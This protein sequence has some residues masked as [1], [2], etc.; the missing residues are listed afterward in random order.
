MKNGF[1]QSMAWLHTWTGL[2]VGWLLLLIFMAGTASYYREEI[3]RW[4]RPELPR[5]TV[6][7]DVAA[8]RA[9]GFLQHKAPQAESW[10]VSLPDPRTPAMRMFWR[11][12][13]S[14]V[15]PPAEGERRRRG[16][17]RFG[18]ATVDPGT[19]QEVAARET[20]GGDFFY[21]LHFDLHY[22]PVLWAR[23]LVGFCAMFMLVAI[24]TGVITHKKIF[25][26]FFTFRR[27]KGLRSW[28]DFHN[29]SA[30]MA[31]PYHAMIT[32]TGIVT[33][34]FMYL[35]WGVGVAY[36]KDEE[37]FFSEAFARLAEIQT[38]AEGHA[39]A[40]PIQQLLDGARRHWKGA[41][42]AGFTLYHPG[43]ANAVID[44]QQRDGKRLSV[45]TPSLRYNA[46]TGALIQ[47]S[48]ASGG[49]TQTRGVMYGLHLARFADWGLRA[50]FFLSG[51]VGCLMVAS[52]VVLWAVKE[53]PKHAKS[54]RIGFG[55]RLVDALNI[56][57]VAG[58]P[59]AF[60]AY[61][62][63]NRLL[64][65][66]L[67]ERADAEINVFF[68]AWGAA[69]LAAFVWPK[70]LM[71]AWQ[72][73]LGAALFALIPLVNAL[74]TQAHLGV[75]L[76]NGDWVLAGFDLVMLAF[77]AM[78]AYCGLRMQRWQPALSPAEK[79]KRQVA[80]AAAKVQEGA[81]VEAKA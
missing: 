13:E 62:L 43:A 50:L 41:D 39:V 25:K 7:S 72:L 42:V 78:L 80:A 8:E 67:A 71:W 38:P 3:S 47:A 65:L 12:P 14:M 18:D 46:V 32:Y 77:G 61:F 63:G 68:Y 1:R 74:T 21:R 48:P 79:K 30:V 2:L 59:I 76:R 24:I 19:G 11:N 22:L 16:G 70:R 69:L 55:L 10:N 37:A 53:R 6:S 31:L 27:D 58:L 5:S 28:L 23:Y 56:G 81:N 45:D 34:M 57:A 4:M 66:Q 60:A 26:D 29:V 40:L 9:L 17:G 54:G 15:K 51:L 52:G 20:R 44:I 36:P 73:Y 33:L 49:A 35:P 75:T 64:P